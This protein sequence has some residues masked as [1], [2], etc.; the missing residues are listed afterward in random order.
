[1]SCSVTIKHCENCG[2]TD[3]EDV[4]ALDGYTG[5]CNELVAFGATDC[6]NFHGEN[7]D[8]WDTPSGYAGDTPN[9]AAV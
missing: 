5:C 2:S 7:A 4:Q 8:E 6:R 1:M 9:Q 3:P